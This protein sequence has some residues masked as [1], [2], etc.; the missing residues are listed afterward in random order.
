MARK[1]I[2][3]NLA[4]DDQKGLYYAC[5]NYGT[6]ADGRRDRRVRTFTDL[7]AAELA[8]EQFQQGGGG[9]VL[10][11]AS[12]LTL[13]EWLEYWLEEVIAP[14]R[15]YT[16]YYCYRSLI[17]NHIVPAL[18]AVRLRQLEPWHI[19]EYYAKKMR[20]GR[21]DSNSVHKHH[22][23]LH[24]ALRLAFRQKILGE[25]PVERVE[26]PREH[27]T[28]QLYY[29]PEQ[30]RDLFQAVEG[31]WLEPVVKLGAY[32]G[33][34]RGEICGLRWSDVDFEQGVIQIRVTRTTAGYR[35]VEK[36]PKTSN[37]IRTLGIAGLEDLT[38]LLQTIRREQLELARTQSHY[39]DS[40]YV[41]AD[42]QGQPRHPNLVTWAFR[43]FVERR[44]L[45]PITI[46]GLRHTFASLANSAR[47]PLV[48]I[49]KALGHKDVSITG[50]IY[51]HIF[52][53]THQEV[54]NTVA[55]RI[56]AG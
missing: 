56:A 23:L 3:K 2:K 5:F 49:G 30:L 14:N 19:Q 12:R 53:Q 41:L 21:L 42:G 8:L 25:N 35:V 28:R 36:Q 11:D 47:I 54:L 24:T 37:S 15:A 13:A 26:A 29:T 4:Y 34:R 43:T 18:G 9:R 16:T 17:K 7:S 27:P 48:D 40:G 46:H 31:S 6:T 33:L 44:G 32:L 20:E 1:T 10:R 55:A 52:D 45:P 22:I 51:T 38:R 50:R 39:T